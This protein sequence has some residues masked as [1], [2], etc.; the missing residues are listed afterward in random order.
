M[1]RQ[2]AP[3]RRYT[4]AWGYFKKWCTGH[5]LSFLPAVPLTVALYLLMLTQTANSFST[6]KMAS[7]AIPAFHSFASQPEVTRAPIVAAIREHAR[8][9]LP[10]GENRKEPIPFDQG[11]GGLQGSCLS[12]IRPAT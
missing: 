1:L 3:L 6:V 7:A 12:A 10:S 9:S 5:D 2:P 8:R 4:P 11:G